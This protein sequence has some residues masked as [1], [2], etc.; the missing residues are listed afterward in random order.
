MLVKLTQFLQR[1]ADFKISKNIKKN[2]NKN[3]NAFFYFFVRNLLPKPE[4]VKLEGSL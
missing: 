1:M 4:S 2:K 3:E